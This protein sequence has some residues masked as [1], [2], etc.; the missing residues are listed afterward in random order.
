VSTASAA[1]NWFKYLALAEN[2]CGF[3]FQR[4]TNRGPDLSISA[5]RMVAAITRIQ[6]KTTV[7]RKTRFRSRFN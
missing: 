6:A 7:Y 1:A 2:L 4:T 3:C 5:V